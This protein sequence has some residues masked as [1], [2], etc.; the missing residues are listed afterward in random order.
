MI[1]AL[2]EL[3]A[4][5]W[6]TYGVAVLLVGFSKTAAPGL[7]VAVVALLASA[8]PARASTGL[9]LTVLIS[10][11]VTAVMPYQPGNIEVT[12][13]TYVGMATDSNDAATVYPQ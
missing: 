12:G 11:D 9:L 2:A 4:L 6:A 13:I 3:S 5:Q 7:G 8:F 1:P 10:G